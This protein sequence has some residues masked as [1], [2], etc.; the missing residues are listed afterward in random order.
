[1][2]TRSQA[3]LLETIT[4]EESFIVEESEAIHLT[5][6]EKNWFQHAFMMTPARDKQFWF[7]VAH[8]FNKLS[9]TNGYKKVLTADECQQFYQSLFSKPKEKKRKRIEETEDGYDI[10][11]KLQQIKKGT[12]KMTRKRMIRS[13]LQWA[14][15]EHRDDLFTKN[16]KIR[17]TKFRFSSIGKD[18]DS[19]EEQEIRK[20]FPEGDFLTG[21]QQYV[22][23]KKAKRFEFAE[24]KKIVFDENSPGILRN[25]SNMNEID[26][27]VS[28]LPKRVKKQKVAKK[29]L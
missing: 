12:K 16:S 18:V 21:S 29:A 17:K 24:E 8:N 10:A 25:I 13:I 11:E 27:Y 1:M 5:E 14:D 26:I 3:K 9:R 22:T 2:R 19:S 20:H 23:P 15:K 4:S 6:L 7:R 28:K